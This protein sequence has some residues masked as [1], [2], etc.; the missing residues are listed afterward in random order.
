MGMGP[1][2]GVLLINLGTPE[3]PRTAEVRRYL[4]EFLSDPRVVDINPIGRW[5][6]LN[7]VILPFRPKRSAEAYRKIWTEEGSPL[8]VHGRALAGKVAAALGGDHEVVLAMRY[9]SP[10]IAAGLARLRE[11]GVERIVVLPLFPHEAESS[12]GS[13]LA[14]V[15]DEASR[16]PQAPPLAIV[17]AFY[18]HPAFIEALSIT[19]RPVLDELAPDHVLLSFHG[20][21]VRH[22]LRADPGGSH[23]L[24]SPS[25]CDA[26][27]ERNGGCYRAQC[28]ATARA[29]ASALDI[30]GGGLSVAFQSRLG[31]TEWIG[32]QTDRV[33]QELAGRGVRRLCVMCPGFVAD[34]LETLEEIGIR[35]DETFRAAGGERLHLVPCLNDHDAWVDAVVRMVREAA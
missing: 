5:A 23:C 33:V 8:L 11:A 6:L 7:L 10:S 3:A 29:L 16:L 4:R 15:A 18:R 35:A 28:H 2:T 22:V 9:G 1:K 25:C 30:D 31:R 21:P 34:C 27:G 26:I 24:V 19:A 17:P 12:T 20:L 32:P 14:K 13:T